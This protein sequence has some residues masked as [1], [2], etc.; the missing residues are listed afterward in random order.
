MRF[1]EPP[2]WHVARV[3][4]WHQTKGTHLRKL[5]AASVPDAIY[6]S[7]IKVSFRPDRAEEALSNVGEELMWLL[8]QL[9]TSGGSCGAGTMRGRCS[10]RGRAVGEE[11][12]GR[13]SASSSRVVQT[14]T[15][16]SR[17]VESFELVLPRG[18]PQESYVQSLSNNS[19]FH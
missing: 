6:K 5:N 10:E 11:A 9:S 17:V 14:C 4:V 19:G 1:K 16:S 18:M 15:T 8:R 12:L 3:S 7:V 13:S 2:L